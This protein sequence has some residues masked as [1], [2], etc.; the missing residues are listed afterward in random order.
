MG[1]VV[2]IRKR[3]GQLLAMI[4]G[5]GPW[6]LVEHITIEVMFTWLCSHE[7]VV[8]GRTDR[9]QARRGGRTVL[10]ETG[11]GQHAALGYS[12]C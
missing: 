5:W 4:R 12:I 6:Y 3:K 7:R 10:Q 8:G 11:V 1:Q 9:G 2:A